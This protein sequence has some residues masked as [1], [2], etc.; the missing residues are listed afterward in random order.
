MFLLFAVTIS[1]KKTW[2]TKWR[3]E[4]IGGRWNVPFW[5][6]TGM[7]TVTSLAA[8]TRDVAEERELRRF[9]LI[10]HEQTFFYVCVNYSHT[11]TEPTTH[12]SSFLLIFLLLFRHIAGPQHFGQLH[13]F[14][15]SLLWFFSH[16]QFLLPSPTVVQFFTEDGLKW[17]YSSFRNKLNGH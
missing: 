12:P 15:F 11:H 9:I 6:F 17:T 1:V 5:T 2:R 16:L 13:R 14:F 7:Q 8:H 3:Q 4:N 10:L